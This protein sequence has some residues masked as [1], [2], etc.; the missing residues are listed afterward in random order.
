MPSG[1]LPNTTVT[2][3]LEQ[4]LPLV[5]TLLREE[6]KHSP[7]A[8]GAPRLRLILALFDDAVMPA[9]AAT[10]TAAPVPLEGLPGP[11]RDK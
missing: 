5:H 6:L 2:T 7:N 11:G 9:L 3:Q 8:T 10:S 4:A 1:V